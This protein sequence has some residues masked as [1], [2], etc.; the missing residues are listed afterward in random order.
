MR[1][2]RESHSHLHHLDLGDLVKQNSFWSVKKIIKTKAT[3][4][5]DIIKAYKKYDRKEIPQH[6]L[7]KNNKCTL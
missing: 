4:A 7:K 3:K 1:I 6:G 5:S 2:H